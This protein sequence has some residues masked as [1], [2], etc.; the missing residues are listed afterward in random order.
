MTSQVDIHLFKTCNSGEKQIESNDQSNHDFGLSYYSEFF[1]G[2]AYT[3][4]DSDSDGD[5]IAEAY[6]Y[7]LEL[8]HPLLLLQNLMMMKDCTTQTVEAKFRLFW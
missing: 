5:D 7:E 6:L 2:S 4:S 3:S 1:A 8:E